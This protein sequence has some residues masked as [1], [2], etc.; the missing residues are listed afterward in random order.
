MPLPFNDEKSG[1]LSPLLNNGVRH[2]DYSTCRPG[3]DDDNALCKCSLH[4][5]VELVGL[6]GCF[7]A[8]ALALLINIATV[9][10]I[11]LDCAQ[12]MGRKGFLHHWEDR[13]IASLLVSYSLTRDTLLTVGANTDVS[14]FN[15][16]T[17]LFLTHANLGSGRRARLGK[18]AWRYLFREMFFCQIVAY[19]IA[20]MSAY[21]VVVQR[22]W[23]QHSE[24]LPVWKWLVLF[25]APP[26][27]FDSW[28]ENLE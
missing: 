12:G 10:I 7:A 23:E 19:V 14:Q 26:F 25:L 15:I 22:A 2:R 28:L 27:V 21:N 6:W 3:N 11:K 17:S 5:G 9:F 16:F 4:R 8:F 18:R 20:P 1:E 13:L 24:R